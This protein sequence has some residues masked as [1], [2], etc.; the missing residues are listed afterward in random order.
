ML[1]CGLTSQ[2]VLNFLPL[3][4]VQS[5][6]FSSL[7]NFVP[8]D[9]EVQIDGELKDC[10]GRIFIDSTPEFAPPLDKVIDFAEVDVIL[11]SNYMNMLALPFITE[12]TGFTGTV[13]ATEPTLQIGRF[14]LE[15]LVEYIELSPKAN[16]ACQWKEVLRSLPLPLS[17]S[18]KPKTW[19]HIFSMEAVQNSLARVQIAGYDQK[20]DIFGALKVTP[21]SSGFCLGSSNWIINS[22]HEKIAY[23]SGSSTLTTHPR[24]INQ[25]ALKNA[26]VIIMTALTQAPHVNPDGMLG[27]L[28]MNVAVTL[29]NG[30]SVLIPCY[31]SGVVYDLFECLSTNLDNA[32]FSQVPMFFISP[33]A[34][35]SLAYSNILAEWLSTAKQNRVYIPDEPFPHA[36]LVKNARLKHFKHIYSEGFSAEFR[37]PCVVFCGH[38]SLRFGDAVHFIEL[39]GSN[40]LHTVIFT[41]PDFPYLQ[42]L[43]PFQPVAMK[44]VYCPIETSLNFQQANKLI[45]ELKPGCLVVPESY[46]LPPIMTPHKTDLVIEPL[47]DKKLITFKRGDVVK[48]PLKRTQSRAYL[49]PEIALEILPQEISPGLSV[50]TITGQLRVKDNLHDISK[51]KDLP[52]ETSTDRKRKQLTINPIKYEWGTLNVDQL[53]KKLQQD[54][55]SDIKVEQVGQ[56]SVR[57]G[58][59]SDDT[60]ITI[61]ETE[62]KIVCGGKQSLRIKIRDMLLQCVQSF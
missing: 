3:P 54:G 39:W 58:M 47:P 10:C 26:D 5:Y 18:Y 50:A 7:P 31:P 60:T 44:A 52:P 29:R 30:G 53:I 55:H 28:C 45:K 25:T 13:F 9:S 56:N 27:E 33:V 17:E 41:E 40:P 6:R 15:E 57:I 51:I 38:P 4:L 34:D 32:G 14:F 22:G 11:I 2:S 61:S 1:D 35:S 62:T 49:T 8:R 48:L 16:H 37:Q 46:T 20:L 24:P 23:I 12:N 21:V 59:P 43:A 19:K 42:A 36:M